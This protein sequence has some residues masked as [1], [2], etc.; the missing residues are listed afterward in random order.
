MLT[1]LTLLVVLVMMTDTIIFQ[2]L[3][4]PYQTNEKLRSKN[5]QEQITFNNSTPVAKG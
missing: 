4:L 1:Q 2:S 5:I 3:I